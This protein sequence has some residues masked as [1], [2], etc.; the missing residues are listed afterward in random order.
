MNPETR[1]TNKIMK[2]LKKH[3]GFWVKIHGSAFQV[4]GIPDI[5]GCY[6]GLFVALEVKL[7]ET[8]E[9]ASLRQRLMMKRIRAAGGI[10]MIVTSTEA[11]LE[12]VEKIDSVR[13][14]EETA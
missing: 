12:V 14:N 2:A 8:A 5:L 13:S 11:A 1:L 6:Q 7:P 9:D 4:S 3:G 10:P